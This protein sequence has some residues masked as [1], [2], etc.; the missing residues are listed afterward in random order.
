MG[1][2]DSWEDDGLV[3]YWGDGKRGERKGVAE[4]RKVNRERGLGEGGRKNKYKSG[5]C[6]EEE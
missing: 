3:F 4:H 6:E 5:Y 1:R 2:L